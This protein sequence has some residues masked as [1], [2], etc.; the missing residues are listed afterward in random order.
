MSKPCH[1][2]DVTLD[3]TIVVRV[4]ASSEANAAHAAELLGA[5]HTEGLTVLKSTLVEVRK[6]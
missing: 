2:Y 3:V 4:K 1:D 6:V 5:T